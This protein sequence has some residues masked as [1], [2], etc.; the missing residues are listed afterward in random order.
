[1][2]RRYVNLQ[3]GMRELQLL[4]HLSLLKAFGSGITAGLSYGTVCGYPLPG[5]KTAR[6]LSAPAREL[7]VVSDRR[8]FVAVKE[9]AFAVLSEARYP[10]YGALPL[11][12]PYGILSSSGQDVHRAAVEA[13]EA[14]S[15]PA[16]AGA[17]WQL[18]VP[19]MVYDMHQQ[20]GCT[21]ELFHI[22]HRLCMGSPDLEGKTT[23]LVRRMESRDD[24][25]RCAVLAL[26]CVLVDVGL[27]GE[28]FAVSPSAMLHRLALVLTELGD[29]TGLVEPLCEAALQ[30][31][32]SGPMRLLQSKR[33]LG[34]CE[35]PRP[36]AGHANGQR[37]GTLTTTEP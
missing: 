4:C 29:T 31:A 32:G 9:L 6:E 13:F 21:P 37:R 35:Q 8:Y 2:A 19:Y 27:N 23:E 30:L 3:P 17:Q 12:R 10:L 15:G 25:G 36:L 26:F 11:P 5:V 34:S 1:M 33:F 7:V 24:H 22:L 20:C 28:Q 14:L 16:R 18:H